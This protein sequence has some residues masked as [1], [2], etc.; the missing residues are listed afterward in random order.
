MACPICGK[1]FV[2]CNCCRQKTVIDVEKRLQSLEER[3]K[4]LETRAMPTDET[5]S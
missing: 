3:I 1:D 4:Q 2:N 5:K